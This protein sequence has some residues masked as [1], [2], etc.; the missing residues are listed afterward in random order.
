MAEATRAYTGPQVAQYA[1][2]EYRTL[3]NWI[4]AGWLGFHDASVGSGNTRRYTIWQR[5]RVVRMSELVKA[6]LTPRV[7]GWLS[8]STQKT[9]TVLSVLVQHPAQEPTRGEGGE[10]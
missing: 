2:I 7:A 6:G 9:D 10:S 4:R 5:N 3:H 8:E 1:G